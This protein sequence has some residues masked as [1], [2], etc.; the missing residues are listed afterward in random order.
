MGFGNHKDL[1]GFESALFGIL[2]STSLFVICSILLPYVGNIGCRIK[3]QDY[4]DQ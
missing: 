3:E 2:R 1:R 4:R